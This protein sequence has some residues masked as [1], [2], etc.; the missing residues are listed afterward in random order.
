[1]VATICTQNPTPLTI[2]LKKDRNSTFSEQRHDAYLIKG[3]YE[4]SNMV[5]NI[6]PADPPPDTGDGVNR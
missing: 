2:G 4:C 6:L 3:N 1:M 5:A